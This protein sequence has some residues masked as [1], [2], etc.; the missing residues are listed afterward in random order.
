MRGREIAGL[1]GAEFIAKGL[2]RGFRE[3]DKTVVLPLP[4]VLAEPSFWLN[5][6]LGF[7]LPLGAFVSKRVGD[8]RLLLLTVWGAHHAT[9]A[10]EYA[11][12]AMTTVGGAAV[13][14]RYVPPSGGVALT[15]GTSAGRY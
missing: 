5:M 1:Y 6:I 11:E 7:G 2:E 13:S 10:V 12:E 3:I 4:S 15:Q 14:V 8:E 9:T